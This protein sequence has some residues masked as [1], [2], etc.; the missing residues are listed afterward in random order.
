MR[1][2]NGEMTG[3]PLHQKSSSLPSPNHAHESRDS[4]ISATLSGGRMARH[5]DNAFS[6]SSVTSPPLNPQDKQLPQKKVQAVI[7]FLGLI[8]RNW[9]NIE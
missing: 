8:V 5:A 7:T 4:E 6:S 1:E 3:S 2:F 9:E